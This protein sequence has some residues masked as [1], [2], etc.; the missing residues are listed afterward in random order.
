MVSRE[1]PMSLAVFL[2]D[3]PC[4]MCI[5]MRILSRI[6]GFFSLANA[7][8]SSSRVTGYVI[9]SCVFGIRNTRVYHMYDENSS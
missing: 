5:I 6:F 8:F 2:P 4:F 7:S 3:S 9:L 1:R